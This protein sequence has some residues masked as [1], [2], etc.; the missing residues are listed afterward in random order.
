MPGLRLTNMGILRLGL[1]VVFLSCDLAMLGL[2]EV[3][4]LLTLCCSV[5][6]VDGILSE[7][8]PSLH[9]HIAP[10]TQ[11]HARNLVGLPK[12]VDDTLRMSPDGW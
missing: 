5:D 1:A 8:H 6:N 11:F 12:H 10:A 9:L 7:V 4:P 3:E 2:L